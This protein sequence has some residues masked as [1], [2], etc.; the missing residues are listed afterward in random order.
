MKTST[1]LTVLALTLT[2]FGISSAGEWDVSGFIGF[3]TRAFWEDSQ[4]L[5][6]DDDLNG[7][8]IVQ[9]EVYWQSDDAKQRFGFV[10][11]ARVDSVDD[12]RTHADIRELHWGYEGNGWDF[13]LG[14]NKV[15]WGVTESRHLVDVI[16]QTDLVE[17]IDQEDKL[18]QPMVN[19]NLQRNFG[20]FELFVLPYFRE[21]TFPGLDGRLRT[22]L[23]VD[24]DDALYESSEEEG[25]VDFAFRYSHY[26]GDVDLAA[27]VFDGTSREPTFRLSAE[28]NRL[29]PFYEQMTQAGFELQYTRDAW[30]WKLEAI[31]RDATS[32]SFAAAVGGLEYTFYG[33]RNSAVDIGV[34]AEYLYDDRDD[35][36]P[37]TAFDK[38][39]FI[40]TRVALNDTDDTS[41]LAGFALDVDTHEAFLNL[42]AEKRFGDKLFGELRLRAFANAD[43]GD[44]TYAFERDDYVQL[45]LSWY[46]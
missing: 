19:V 46:Y 29:V 21:R 34:L 9:P 24:T 7:S 23:P 45:R 15:F 30:L 6:Q 33:V 35:N 22:P 26:V 4:F 32:D 13:N 37:L 12:E 8:P 11:F 31:G 28:R 25:H 10:G 43:P 27:Y 14:I 41:I 20:R 44:A 3:D 18:G 38:D 42:E 17:D 2:P 36:A 16:N 5:D 1:I 40:G 39:V